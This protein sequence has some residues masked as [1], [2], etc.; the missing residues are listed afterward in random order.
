ML[1]SVGVL[2][3]PLCFGV[4]HSPGPLGFPNSLMFWFPQF[5]NILNFLIIWFF[6]QVFH[7]LLICFPQI[8]DAVQTNIFTIRVLY[9]NS[10]YI[11]TCNTLCVYMGSMYSIFSKDW[12]KNIFKYWELIWRHFFALFL[13]PLEYLVWLECSF[14][15]LFIGTIQLSSFL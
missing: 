2:Q 8:P 10:Y 5:P 6:Q 15:A 13:K 3:I 7:S 1:C 9:W 4:S 11:H 14:Q 12:S